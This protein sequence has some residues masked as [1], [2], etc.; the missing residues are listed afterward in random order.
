MTTAL[1]LDAL[2]HAIFTRAQEGIT[3]LTGLI[4]H[5]DAGSQY[6]SVAFTTDCSTKASTPR[7]GQSATPRTTRWPRPPSARSRTS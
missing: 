3:D 2:E 7:S 5:S 6:T 1:V 4:A